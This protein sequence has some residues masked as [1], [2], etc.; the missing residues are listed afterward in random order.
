[1]LDINFISSEPPKY[2]AEVLCMQAM[3]HAQAGRLQ[4]A[5]EFAE[6]ARNQHPN[7][8]APYSALAFI[9][10]REH[11]FSDAYRFA[12]KAVMADPLN[13]DAHN[14]LSFAA[15]HLG[16]WDVS[17]QALRDSVKINPVGFEPRMW[18][19]S[20]LMLQGDWTNGLA[21]YEARLMHFNPIPADQPS[22][23]WQGESLKGMSI[24]LW[25]EQGLGDQIQ[26]ARYARTLKK[27]Y[28]AKTVGIVCQPSLVQLLSMV[29]YVD[30]VVAKKEAAA[31]ELPR[32]DY[33]IPMMSVMKHLY[34]DHG[35]TGLFS[36]APDY[37]RVSDEQIPCKRCVGLCWKGNPE[38]ANDYFRSLDDSLIA[39]LP[40]S[41]GE[42]RNKPRKIIY[43]SLQHGADKE[44]ERLGLQQLGG[45]SIF[46][47]ARIIHYLD[48]VITVDTMTAHLAG[49]MGKPVWV[50]LPANP[51][52]RW[53]LTGMST[54][55]YPSMRLFRQKKLGDWK[56]VL[57]EVATALKERYV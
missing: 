22:K 43:Q 23:L 49:A 8:C 6:T 46:Q 53:G 56:P 35:I 12:K 13:A 36:P 11:R 52:W 1:M 48:L 42:S 55:W 44:A 28:G 37:L 39:D 33:R 14:A 20:Q 30:W 34:R 40:V 50:L 18:L 25:G 51:D 57:E 9:A 41:L 24:V 47:V 31:G 2:P 16:K 17:I 10:N 29:E 19:A 5:T 3:R 32:H 4:E 45:N 21:L 27:L 26:F 38:H 54:P 7:S 15:F